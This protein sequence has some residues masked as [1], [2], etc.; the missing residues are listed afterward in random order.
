MALRHCLHDNNVKLTMLVAVVMPD[1]V[2]L[3]F[4]P[5]HDRDDLAYTL[6]EIMGG[7]KGSSSHS[8]NRLLGR[9]GAL[10]QDESF[11]HA[12]RRSEGLSQKVNYVCNN[13]VRRGLVST[14]ENYPWLWR[15]WVEGG[16]T[17]FEWMTM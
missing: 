5:H 10:W 4:Y 11:D 16:D 13:P 7:L 2:H 3:V 9:R 1:H 17:D 15:R 8:I 12:I 14:E 6:R